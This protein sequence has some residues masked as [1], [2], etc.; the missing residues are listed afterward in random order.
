MKIRPILIFLF[1]MLTL[2]YGYAQE[3]LAMQESRKKENEKLITPPK[4]D[5]LRI[6]VSRD[7]T[8]LDTLLT[9]EKGLRHNVANRDLFAFLPFANPG[10]PMN[11]LI[12]DLPVSRPSLGVPMQH[13][14]LYEK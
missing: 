11:A 12:R 7:T 14:M 1:C 10:R 8:A 6:S 4:S 13:Y 9:F 3:E 5:Y 2:S